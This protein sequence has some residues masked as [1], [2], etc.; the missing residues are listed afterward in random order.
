MLRAVMEGVS[1]ETK[2]MLDTLLEADIAPAR[3]LR[4]IGGASNNVFWNQIQADIYGLPIETITAGEST[5]LGA[6]IICA[7]AIGAYPDHREAV[8][9]MTHVLKQYQPDPENVEKY[10]AV[11]A[12][13]SQCY[14]D[15]SRG[16]FLK[17]GQ[18]QKMKK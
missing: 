18:L 4:L 5:A 14:Q 15:L 8:R 2:M 10:R 17:I 3:S 7:V 12:A 16:T 1:F 11:Y 13:W 9:N 6:A